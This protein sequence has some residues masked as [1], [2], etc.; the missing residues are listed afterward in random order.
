M[1]LTQNMCKGQNM[2][3]W[4][5]KVMGD[6]IRESLKFRLGVK[7]FGSSDLYFS[8]EGIG[9]S[10]YFIEVLSAFGGH[11]VEGIACLRYFIIA[12]NGEV[13]VVV[14]NSHLIKAVDDCFDSAP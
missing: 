9:E 14:A 6:R 11:L 8:F 5:V 3:D 13:T 1:L 10:L 7:E 12:L 2:A 4:G